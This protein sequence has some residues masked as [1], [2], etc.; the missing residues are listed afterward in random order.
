[1]I[2]F[3]SLS[4]LFFIWDVLEMTFW[5]P[6]R[7]FGLLVLGSRGSIFFYF[8]DTPSFLRFSRCST[9]AIY[10]SSGMLAAGRFTSLSE[11]SSSLDMTDEIKDCDTKL[12]FWTES[13]G[14]FIF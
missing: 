9:K 7:A 13:L 12:G 1:L 3:S 10:S 4:S 8:W 11:S 14:L 6:I 5:V 2:F